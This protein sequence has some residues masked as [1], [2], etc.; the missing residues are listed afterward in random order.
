MS[1]VDSQLKV[2]LIIAEDINAVVHLL[3]NDSDFKNESLPKIDVVEW[4]DKGITSG[5]FEMSDYIE[6]AKQISTNYL[7]YDGFVVLDSISTIPYTASYLSFML[8]NLAKPI[9]VTGSYS[10]SLNDLCSDAKPNILHSV[11]VAGHVNICEVVVCFNRHIFRGNRVQRIDASSYHPFTSYNYPILGEFVAGRGLKLTKHCLREA[12]KKGFKAYTTLCPNIIVVHLIPQLT[13]KMLKLLL[14]AQLTTRNKGL[15]LSIFLLF[16]P[17]LR[18][19]R[20]VL[21]IVALICQIYH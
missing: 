19:I 17:H 14:F 12:V 5:S 3:E 13:D 4:R 21:T 1:T 8:E 16:Q 9:V 7:D 18:H 11:I 15:T 10:H 20:L 6:I 2:L